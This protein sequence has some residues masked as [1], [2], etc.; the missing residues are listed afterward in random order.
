LPSGQQ[1]IDI[2]SRQGYATAAQKKEAAADQKT[3]AK[4]ALVHTSPVCRV[5][6]MELT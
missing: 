1:I 5:R 3:A 2:A 4:A 6:G